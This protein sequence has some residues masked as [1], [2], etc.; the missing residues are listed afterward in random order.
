RDEVACRQLA[1]RARK[2]IAARRPRFSSDPA[3]RRT[4]SERF[5]AACEGRDLDGLLQLLA[6]DATLV[7]DGG[8]RTRAAL[9]EIHGADRVARFLVG[10]LTKRTGTERTLPSIHG[11]PGM[12][13]IDDEGH[14]VGVMST[15]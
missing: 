3:Q 11:G 13:W 10:V 6:P 7:S 2:A 4:V 8:G 1:S 15:S 5:L 12:A 14:L 9:N